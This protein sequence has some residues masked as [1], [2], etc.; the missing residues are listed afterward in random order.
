MKDT[1]K[2]NGK[3]IFFLVNA[4]SPFTLESLCAKHLPGIVIESAATLPQNTDDYALVIP[5]NYRRILPATKLGPNF[6][7]F[8]PSDLPEGKG[9]APLYNTIAQGK[10]EYVLSVFIPD[11]SMDGGDIVA[12]ARFKMTPDYTAAILRRHHEEICVKVMALIIDRFNNHPITGAKQSGRETICER[13]HPKDSEISPDKKLSEL[14]PHLRACEPAHP[15]FFYHE[16]VK[17]L[18]TVQPEVEP[19][20]PKDFTIEFFD[21]KEA[22]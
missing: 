16:G 10:K 13:R 20:S 2:R 15:A 21:G 9:W 22:P 11:A 5:W 4:D 6:L 17:Y 19:I 7:V 18:I 8:H 3:K 12:K 14:L 1:M